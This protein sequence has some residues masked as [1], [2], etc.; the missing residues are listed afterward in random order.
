MA[1]HPMW[2]AKMAP[3]C[4]APLA[5]PHITLTCYF[6]WLLATGYY[7]LTAP[8]PTTTYYPL[9]TMPLACPIT[10]RK[11]KATPSRWCG[12][13]L[14]VSHAS[15]LTTPPHGPGPR[16]SAPAASTMAGGGGGGGAAGG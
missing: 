3:V 9:L 13:S 1:L 8:S 12:R 7:L 16:G 15:M 11:R 10:A 5:C 4:A 14:A 2:S 6:Y